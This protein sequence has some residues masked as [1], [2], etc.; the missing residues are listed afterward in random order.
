MCHFHVSIS[1]FYVLDCWAF[2]TL[3]FC[4]CHCCLCKLVVFVILSF[5]FYVNRQNSHSNCVDSSFHQ[6][7]L[8]KNWRMFD[9]HKNQAVC[10]DWLFDALNLEKSLLS[11]KFIILS[12]ESPNGFIMK[13]PLKKSSLNILPPNPPKLLITWFISLEGS[14]RP[15]T[16]NWL[17][18]KLCE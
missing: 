4:L 5:H 10:F 1:R 2:V 9:I 14:C 15:K 7:P 17:L 3:R 11:E 12:I 16:S 8:L 6:V 18:P 13:S